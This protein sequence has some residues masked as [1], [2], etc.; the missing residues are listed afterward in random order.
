MTVESLGE[1]VLLDQVRPISAVAAT[2]R[3]PGDARCLQLLPEPVDAKGLLGHAGGPTMAEVERS[4]PFAVRAHGEDVL[5]AS[6]G[7]HL[8]GHEVHAQARLADGAL[9]PLQQLQQHLAS[10]PF[11]GGAERCVPVRV[12]LGGAEA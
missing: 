8:A 9:F 3:A 5:A 7:G 1:L 4:V 12:G 6:A 10:P 11:L 2:A